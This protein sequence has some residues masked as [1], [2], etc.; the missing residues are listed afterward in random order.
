MR[1]TATEINRI[2]GRHGAFWQEEPFDHLVRHAEQ[3][4]AIRLYIANNP[5]KAHLKPGE[6]F[7]YRRP[8]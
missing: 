4:N 8:D 2:V 1:F 7:Y 3:Y 5:E 6:Y